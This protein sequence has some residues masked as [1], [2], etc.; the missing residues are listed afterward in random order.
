MFWGTGQKSSL[1]K[2]VSDGGPGDK[3]MYA[4]LLMWQNTLVKL[5]SG[6]FLPKICMG[7]AAFYFWDPSFPK[8]II[9]CWLKNLFVTHFVTSRRTMCLQWWGWSNKA[10]TIDICQYVSV[11]CSQLGFHWMAFLLTCLLSKL[12]V[13]T[14]HLSRN[15][16]YFSLKVKAVHLQQ[17]CS[18]K[19]CL[20]QSDHNSNV[21]TCYFTCPRLVPVFH[22]RI[23][24]FFWHQLMMIKGSGTWI[25][26][27]FYFLKKTSVQFCLNLSFTKRWTQPGLPGCLVLP[28]TICFYG[29]TL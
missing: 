4:C 7:G 26:F 11:C 27:D 20:V 22:C 25:N 6:N 13:E 3:N 19:S 28:V 9:V 12:M 10:H 5:R 23:W 24:Y 2:Y 8:M 18:W 1:S 14:L 15:V 21:R 17:V 29:Q 16:A